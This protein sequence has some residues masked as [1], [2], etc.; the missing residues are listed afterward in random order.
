MNPP[1]N[2]GEAYRGFFLKSE[3]G[4]YFISELSR[5]IDDEHRSAEKNPE[6]SRDHVQRA[7]GMR[8]LEEHIQSVT[9]KKKG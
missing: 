9:I 8:N 2:L 6:L 5:L 3:A 7:K 4:K 1:E